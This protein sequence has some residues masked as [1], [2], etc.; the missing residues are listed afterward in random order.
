MGFVIIS[1]FCTYCFL[2]V[3]SNVVCNNLYFP[4]L[5]LFDCRVKWGLMKQELSI[6]GDSDREEMEKAAST[7]LLTAIFSSL[8][9]VRN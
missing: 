4:Q 5:M 8:F 2:H 6:Y 9:T 1:I 7:W 3:W